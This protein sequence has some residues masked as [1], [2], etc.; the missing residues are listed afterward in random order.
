MQNAPSSINR[1]ALRAFAALL[2]RW[3]AMCAML[4]LTRGGAER[5]RLRLAEQRLSKLIVTLALAR[6]ELPVSVGGASSPRD[7]RFSGDRSPL[8]AYMRLALPKL[9]N[10]TPRARRERLRQAYANLDALVR[11]LIKLMQRGAHAAHFVP[12]AAAHALCATPRH[13]VACADTS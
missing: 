12:I 7:A 3:F 4:W 6:I 13:A 11:R 5:T 1:A 2:R 8:A 10:S 9:A